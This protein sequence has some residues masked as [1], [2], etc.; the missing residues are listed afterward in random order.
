MTIRA[1]TIAD[2]H[3]IA[4]I[5]VASW[6]AAY[7]GLMPDAVLNGLSVPKRAE[8]WRRIVAELKFQL[9][10]AEHDDRI[11]GL[12]NFGPTRNS[13]AVPELTGEILAI[14]VDPD[15]WHGGIG[16]A[17]LEAALSQ[18]KSAGFQ[19]ATLWVLDSNSRARVFYERCGFSVDGATQSEI[20]GDNTTIQ[21]V[22]Y[23]RPL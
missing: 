2:A 6:K 18:L 3:H 11:V 4:Q 12:V 15:R 23:R 13:D 5:H 8:M 22:R 16:Q 1:A 17:L 21:E 20:V 14:Y 9:L 19:E 7:H 10:V